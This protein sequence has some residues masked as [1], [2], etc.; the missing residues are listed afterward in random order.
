MALSGVADGIVTEEEFLEYYTSISASIDNEEY[1]EQMINSSWN[2]SGDAATY[3]TYAKGVAID[4]TRPAKGSRP[5]AA[6]GAAGGGGSYSGFARNNT[7]KATMSSGV[8]SA[9]NPFSTATQ[10]YDGRQ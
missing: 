4:E 9:D 1:F 7:G 8:Q 10:Y 2:I 3:K 6:Q 5:Q